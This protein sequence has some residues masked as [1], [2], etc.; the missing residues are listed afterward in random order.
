MKFFIS[1]VLSTILLV[2]GM[3][4]GLSDILKTGKLLEHARFHSQEHG[5]NFVVFIAKHYGDLKEQHEQQHEE[6]KKEHE[7]LPVRGEITT[8]INLF[9]PIFSGFPSFKSPVISSSAS[10][11]FYKAIYSSPGATAIFQPPRLA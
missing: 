11:F 10:V 6:E 2:P 7:K 8:G 1:I 3:H 5:D 4:F 9:V